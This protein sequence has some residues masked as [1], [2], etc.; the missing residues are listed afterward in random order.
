MG[1]IDLK[2]VYQYYSRKDIQHE[3]VEHAKNKE[4]AVR[5]KDG[6]GK[7]PDVLK[8]DNDV[9]EFVKQ[10]ALSFHSSEELWGNPLQ[11][12]V[13]LRK[14][15][16]D[17]LRIGWDFVLDI[18][19]EHWQLAKITTWLLIKALED[20]GVKSISLKFSG[21]KG[22]HVGVPFEAFPSEINN[23][24]TMN[25]FPEGPK[26]IA[27]FL[28]DYVKKKYIDVSNDG[29]I[30]FNKKFKVSFDKL[31]EITGKTK[32]EL[33][34]RYCSACKK[35]I[36][37]DISIKMDE[38]LCPKCGSSIN[39]DKKFMKCLKCNVLMQKV[40][41]KKNVCSCGSNNFREEFEPL[42]IIKV[43][44]LLISSRHMYRMPYS[45]NEKSGL[46]SMPFN[47]DKIL[48][49]KKEYASMEKIKVS[50]HRFL[51]RT[52][53]IKG[54]A[55]KLFVEAIDYESRKENTKENFFKKE[56]G[57]KEFQ[58]ITEAVPEDYF[59]PCIKLILKGLSDGKKRSVFV[60]VNFL[61]SLGW[62]YEKIEELLTEWNKRNEEPLRENLIVGQIRYHKT[63]K[64]KILPP[65]C[66]SPAYYLD[67]NLC[68][69][70]NLCARIKNPVNYAIIRKKMA[71]PIQKK[72][73]KRK[74]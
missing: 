10:G 32:D 48:D 18:D 13:A 2:K 4:I 1:E 21:N 66:K 46:V 56:S 36:K 73:K 50:K 62:S 45:L 43:D 64:K 55:K 19:C 14:K 68:K 57:E 61:T 42:N 74:E 41:K 3:I 40:S 7:R 33:T 24:K 53:V 17:N 20:F 71:T 29:N 72:T 60:L 59:P 26:K 6:F 63:Q 51:D 49:F 44:T 69:P 31:K 11:L 38:F 5:F 22:F 28:V 52:N 15:E 12:D 25:L 16:L 27:D 67:L 58:K 35:K 47:K 23:G 54:E 37:G 9:L 30:I 39:S 65:N 34:V 8:Y 70:D